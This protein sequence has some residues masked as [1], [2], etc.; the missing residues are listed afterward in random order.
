MHQRDYQTGRESLAALVAA[1]PAGVQHHALDDGRYYLAHSCR[2]CGAMLWPVSVVERS[3][4]AQEVEVLCEACSNPALLPA[5]D[6]HSL[7]EAL[8]DIVLCWPGS[9]QDVAFRR[10]V[11][12]LREHQ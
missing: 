2:W 4:L 1:W 3:G 7:Y 8:R 5:I 11:A 10:A 12:F 9:R 6:A